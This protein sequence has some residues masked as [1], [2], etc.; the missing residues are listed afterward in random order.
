MARFHF[1][2]YETG[3]LN[4]GPDMFLGGGANRFLLSPHARVS[5][6][7]GLTFRFH[8]QFHLLSFISA[9]AATCRDQSGIA[10][11]NTETC[12]SCELVRCGFNYRPTCLFAVSALH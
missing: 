11:Y 4:T 3:R 9:G 12:L 1:I 7:V 2:S 5:T 10:K 8:H 6:I